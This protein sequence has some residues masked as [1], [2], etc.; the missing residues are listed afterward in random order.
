MKKM[1]LLDFIIDQYERSSKWNNGTSGNTSFRI[2]EKHYKIAGKLTLI[3]EAKE[4]ENTGLLKISWVKGYYNIDIEKVEYPLLNME[5]F[6][7]LTNRKPKYIVVEEQK[8]LVKNIFIL[9]RN[10][11]LET[12]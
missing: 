5:H 7:R 6:Y 12:I 3:S 10:H 2:E 4:L 1:K 9:L 8:K 11:G